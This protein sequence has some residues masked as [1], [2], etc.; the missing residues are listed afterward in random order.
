MSFRELLQASRQ[1][2]LD[3]ADEVLTRAE[4]ANRPLSVVEN[5]IVTT[6]TLEAKDL[7]EEIQRH[8]TRNM[9]S[10]R[11]E[12]DLLRGT[13][14]EVSD[15][16]PSHFS[17]EYQRSFFDYCRNGQRS[18]AL[19][20]G[21]NTAG[22]FAVPVTVDAQIVPLAPADGAV[23]KLASVVTTT[24]D[25]KVPQVAA[26]PTASAK[27][28]G[29]AFGAS[30]STLGQFTLSAFT[31]GIEWDGSVEAFDDIPL[32]NATAFRDISLAVQGW[33]EGK[34][35][36]GSGT[37]EPQGL[38]GNID[39][40]VAAATPDAASNLLSIDA[41]FA[42]LDTLKADYDPNASWLMQ[43]STALELRRAQLAA[44]LFEPVFR[45]ENGVDLLHGYPVNYS[46]SMP[47]IAAGATP[48]IFGDFRS[49]YLIGDRGTNA[50]YFKVLDQTK[51]LTGNIVILA[52]RRV[53]GRVR[54]SEALKALTLHT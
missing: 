28:E 7:R 26:L 53:D 19:V 3:R 20:E 41:T 30:T 34:F 40:G 38:L 12:L 17:A 24:A 44:N 32:F 21:T 9:Q 39:T 4:S 2:A 25:R 48:V 49:G 22:G 51:I 16:C 31:V 10:R 35:V 6:A 47:T 46:A 5:D 52:Y 33:E 54:C 43:K 29:S 50:V 23:R 15:I 45:R 18:A 42:I 11:A 8:E 27:S 1:R 36:N 37:G 13:R 14:A